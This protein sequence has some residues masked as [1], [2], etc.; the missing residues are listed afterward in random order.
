MLAFGVKNG[1]TPSELAGLLRQAEAAVRERLNL[2]TL[3]EE[4][5]IAAWREAYRAF[6]AKPSE[7]RPSMEAMARRVLRNQEIPLINTLVDIGNVLSLRHLV[8]T[9]GHAIDLLEGDIELRFASGQ[10]TFKAFDSDEIEH[11]LPGEVVFVEGSTVLT[12]RW[13][14][15]QSDR[16]LTLPTTTAIEFNVDGLPPVT[17]AEVEFVCSEVIDMIRKFCG[18]RTR[19]EILSVENPRIRISE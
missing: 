9:G 11:P 7:F 4:P 3:I 16:T 19:Y 13:T 6:G 5:K 15:R 1:E 12:R 18:G 8:P 17:R 10:E 2:D 14:W